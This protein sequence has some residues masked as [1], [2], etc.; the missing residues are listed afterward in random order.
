MD[1]TSHDPVL[2]RIRVQTALD[3]QL[4]PTWCRS[5]ILV[6]LHLK[7]FSILRCCCV[8]YAVWPRRVISLVAVHV[9]R[10]HDK[11][12]RGGPRERR[13]QKRTITARAVKA[14]CNQREHAHR[15]RH[16]STTPLC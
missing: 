12:K 9:P 15:R 4:A 8:E 2:A 11:D 7:T 13:W 16:T 3:R 1:L 6:E 10:K 5:L 14:A